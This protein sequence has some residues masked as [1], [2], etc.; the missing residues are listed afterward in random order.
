MDNT[1]FAHNHLHKYTSVARSQ[2]RVDVI[3][4]INLVLMKKD[5]LRY[6]Q[7]VIVYLISQGKFRLF[8]DKD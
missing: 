2:D 3:S 1:Y 8:G 7:D 4:L 5:M 6:A